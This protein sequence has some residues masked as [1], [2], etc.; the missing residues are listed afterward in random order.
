MSKLKANC[1]QL[2]L[3]LWKIFQ[4]QKR[5]IIGTLLELIM[6]A[7]FAILLLPI[8]AI[9]KSDHVENA[10]VFK[11]F[12]LNSFDDSFFQYTNSS[13]GYYPNTSSVANALIETVAEQL[14]F[15]Y[16]CIYFYKLNIFI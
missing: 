12:D 4:I 10:T 15:D 14:Y 1:N 11:S 2:K 16:K 6:P 9:I 5:S 3:L 8:R 7:F 13:F